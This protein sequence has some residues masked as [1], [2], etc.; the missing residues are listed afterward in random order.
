MSINEPQ[1]RE[2]LDRYLNGTATV[3][4]KK[5]VDIFF[6]SYVEEYPEQDPE[7]LNDKKK[8]IFLK[9]KERIS[10]HSSTGFYLK[11]WFKVAA[12]VSIII[13]SLWTYNRVSTQP[14]AAQNNDTAELK[15]ESTKR[16]EKLILELPD[17]TKVHINS[18]SSITYPSSFNDTRTVTLRGEAYFE[19]SHDPLR[20]FTVHSQS[21]FVEVLGTT[22]NVNATVADKV[23][24]TLV[25]GKV[26]VN[27]L[28]QELS[29]TPGYQATVNIENNAIE[30]EKVNVEDFIR[31]KDNVLV[32][33]ETPLEKAIEI[34]ED[35]YDI[36]IDLQSPALKNCT[37]SGEYKNESLAVV[38]RSFE[39]LLKAKADFKDKRN[40]T[41]SGNG[42]NLQP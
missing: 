1:F 33:R 17:G 9:I 12:T 32:F 26:N 27:S 34:L 39:F 40:I 36:E 14:S 3:E 13:A 19:V 20:P 29:I 28:T 30:T 35:W 24:V 41:L 31:W 5:I 37:I 18:N 15:A 38:I 16:G 10:S 8:E 21:S 4:E 11:T 42:C 7:T 23:E 2:L 22:F 6:A 25:T